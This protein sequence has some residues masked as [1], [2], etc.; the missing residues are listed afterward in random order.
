M[1]EPSSHS[2]KPPALLE[3]QQLVKHF[4]APRGILARTAP[5]VRA[6]DGVSFTIAPGE[7][8]GL[9]GESGCG[10][11]TVGR[12]VLR[13]EEPTSGGIR[14]EGH[15]VVSLSGAALRRLRRRMQIIFQDPFGSLDPRMTVADIVGEGLIIHRVLRGPALKDR[16]IE[17]LESVGLTAAVARRY[18]HEFSGG[19]RQRLGIAR[20]LALGP[21]FLVCD[22]AVSSLDVSIQAQVLNLLVELRERLRIAYLFIAHDL[23]VVRHV[24]HRVAVMYLGEIVEIGLT[25]ELFQDPKHPYTQALLA[26]APTLDPERR[27]RRILLSGEVPSPTDPPAGCRFHTRC[28]VA[29]PECSQARPPRQEV[30]AT[31]RYRCIL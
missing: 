12:C 13:L 19:Q 10:K 30:S 23:A 28:P 7:T 8:L 20:A 29:R 1:P 17:L 27:R 25:E 22:E 14:F 16:V 4:P 24:S 5:A 31:H 11:T 15:D 9:V 26:A 6:V 21:S 2:P 3:V 18:P